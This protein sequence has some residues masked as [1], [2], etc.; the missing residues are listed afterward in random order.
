MSQALPA[1]VL[2]DELR[3][4]FRGPVIERDDPDY[5]AIR[6]IWNGAIDRRPAL[7]ARCTG[8]A[9][10]IAALTFACERD[11]PVAVRGGGHNVAGTALCEGGLVIDLQLMR[12]LRIDPAQRRLY[13]QPGLRL[14]DVDHETEAFGLAA[15]SGINSETGIS[16]LILGGGIGWLMRK[17]GLTI[18][19]LIAAD[20]VTTEGELVRTSA[21]EDPDLF[22]ARAAAAG[23]SAS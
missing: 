14:A 16:G 12:G 20:V 10:V 7:V 2:V 18:D 5:D 21:D 3:R 19:H 22:W 4:S 15:V 6:R 23:T 13:V 1:Q 17:H 11:L 8:A 9:D